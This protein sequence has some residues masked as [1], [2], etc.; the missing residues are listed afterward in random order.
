MVIKKKAKTFN[1][2]DVQ[3]SW[4][5]LEVIAAALE[6]DH[7]DPIADELHAELHWYMERVPGPGEEEEDAKA[8]EQGGQPV[9]GEG[10]EEGDMPI[11][12]P[13]GEEGAEAAPTPGAEAGG[14]EAPPA[15]EGTEPPPEGG[16]TMTQATMKKAL[17]GEA[18]VPEP[19]LEG[20]GEEERLPKP[21][22]E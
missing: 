9:P 19:G 5:Q 7:S 2:Y 17:A 6:R 18:P 8:R 16:P 14:L 3:L 22:T 11:P 20:G 13:P 15:E 4:G 10:G 21:P 12:M 1:D